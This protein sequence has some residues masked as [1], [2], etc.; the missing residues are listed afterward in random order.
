MTEHRF[1]NSASQE[2]RR[3][4]LRESTYVGRAQTDEAG[5]RFA[6]RIPSTVVG[7]TAVPQYPKLPEGNPWTTDL[8]PEPPLGVDVNGE[9]DAT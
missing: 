1:D 9:P 2:E 5:G 7:S 6:K 8:P 4:V 3:R